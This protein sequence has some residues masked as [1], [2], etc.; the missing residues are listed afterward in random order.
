MVFEQA[1]HI[2]WDTQRGTL[3][4]ESMPKLIRTGY[5]HSNAKETVEQ[6]VR[7]AV[8]LFCKQVINP[9]MDNIHKLNLKTR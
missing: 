5:V 3:H 1:D 9:K 2:F 8:Y 4:S 6:V 7:R